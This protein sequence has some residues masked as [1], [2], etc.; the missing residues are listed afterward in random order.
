[1]NLNSLKN[2]TYRFP[3]GHKPWNKNWTG[4]HLSTETEF[5]K[6]RKDEKHPEWKGEEASYDAKHQWVARWKGRPSLCEDCGTTKA[7]VYNWANISGKYLRD[8]NDYK[9]LCR[10]CHHKFD[11]ISEKI[12]TMRNQ[13]FA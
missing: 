7:K 5:K 8:L 4:L 1:M 10:K 11:K 9:R 13:K 2:L 3:K 6:G 12:W